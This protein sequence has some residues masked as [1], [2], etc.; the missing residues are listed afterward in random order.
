[1]LAPVISAPKTAVENFTAEAVNA[2]HALLHW[3]T[4]TLEQARGHPKYQVSLS[5]DGGLETV[6]NVSNSPIVVGNLTSTQYIV[7]VVAFTKGGKGPEAEGK[8]I[9]EKTSLCMYIH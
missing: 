3:K 5:A 8:K 7:R 2:T 9:A 6:L 1:M 4:L